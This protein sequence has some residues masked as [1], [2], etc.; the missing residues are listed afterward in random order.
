VKPRTHY[1]VRYRRTAAWWEAKVEGAGL[2]T[3]GRSLAQA[4]KHARMMLELEGHQGAELV[5]EVR[6]P[7]AMQRALDRVK[8]ARAAAARASAAERAATTTALRLLLGR[9]RLS[10]RDAAELLALGRSQVCEL[11]GRTKP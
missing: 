9:G 6:L 7:P 8:A 11:A 1:T 5:D 4:R 3:A 10:V 2:E